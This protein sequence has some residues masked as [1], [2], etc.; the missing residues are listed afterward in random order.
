M[1]H[2]SEDE[3]RPASRGFT[4]EHPFVTVLLIV[5]A[6]GV[7]EFAFMFPPLI[8]LE[9]HMS[10]ATFSSLTWEWMPLIAG[11]L[12]MVI[13]ARSVLWRALKLK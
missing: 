13:V 10:E 11:V 4:I 9:R 8:Y 5:L 7:L 12:C 6:M 1:I 2:P 3:T